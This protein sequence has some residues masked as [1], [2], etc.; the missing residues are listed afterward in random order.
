MQ[1]ESVTREVGDSVIE[2]AKL[3][4]DGFSGDIVLVTFATVGSLQLLHSS[5]RLIRNCSFAVVLDI[6]A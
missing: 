2:V 6:S 4:Q 1:V 3:R 5:R